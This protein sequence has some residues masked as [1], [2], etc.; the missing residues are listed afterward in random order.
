M[1]PMVGNYYTK[2][3]S[4]ENPVQNRF[5]INVYFTLSLQLLFT[6][7]WSII[8]YNVNIIRDWVIRNPE[9]MYIALGLSI[10]TLIYSFCAYTR[11][12]IPLILFTLS[13][14]YIIG[15]VCTAYQPIALMTALSSTT[16]ITS[17]ATLYVHINKEKDFSWL[18]PMIIGGGFSFVIM[19]IYTAIFGLDYILNILMGTFG[20]L[21]FTG[22]LV[23]DT[24]LI[25]QRYTPDEFIIATLSLYV[26]FINV[27]MNILRL[28]NRRN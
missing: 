19:G 4:F 22:Y 10:S 26:D 5:V 2:L 15:V 28:F 18:A 21:L 11:S 7:L 14:S 9:Y 8:V 17:C 27:F 1:D 24:Y 16:V 12:I 25:L 13:E 3:E 23:W 20:S 6:S